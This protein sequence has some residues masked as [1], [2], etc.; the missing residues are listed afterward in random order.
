MNFI[1]LLTSTFSLAAP[2]PSWKISCD[3][4]F[5]NLPMTN[6]A[7]A[8]DEN[9]N[10]YEGVKITIQGKQHLESFTTAGIAQNELIHGWISKGTQN[11]IELVIY[12][13]AT[14]NGRSRLTNHNVPFGKDMWGNCKGL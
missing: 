7:L 9:G 13:E 3:Y 11:E 14:P 8:L 4:S 12:K 5:M 6:V 10:L 1:F 2:E